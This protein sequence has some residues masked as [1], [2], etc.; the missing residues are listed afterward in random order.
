M[1][2]LN[3]EDFSKFFLCLDIAFLTY[4]FEKAHIIVPKNVEMFSNILEYS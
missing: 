4:S 3:S 2:R 1:I